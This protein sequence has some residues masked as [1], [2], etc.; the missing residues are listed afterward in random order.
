MD[1]RKIVLTRASG[2][3]QTFVPEPQSTERQYYYIRQDDEIQKGLYGRGALNRPMVFR[4]QVHDTINFTKDMQLYFF[5]LNRSNNE[6]EDRRVFP[7]CCDTWVTNARKIQDRPGELGHADYVNGLRLN[8]PDPSWA[9]LVMGRNVIC[10]EEVISDGSFGIT[11]GVRCLKVETMYPDKLIAGATYETHPHLIHHCNIINS[12]KYENLYKV[13]PFPQRG[14]KL[15]PPKQPVFYPLVWNEPVY[16]EMWMLKKLN[17]GSKIP[18][19]Y[20]PAW[21]W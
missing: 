16:I 9:N 5:G 14:G 2:I 4:L 7:D 10:G 6:A 12:A 13:L 8:R 11:N 15:Y 20:N 18:N 1:S 3:T 17:I 19:P 21:E